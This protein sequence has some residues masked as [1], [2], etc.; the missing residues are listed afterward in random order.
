MIKRNKWFK[1]GKKVTNENKNGMKE[2]KKWYD[3]NETNRVLNKDGNITY[4]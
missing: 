2:K 1:E 4:V 3:L